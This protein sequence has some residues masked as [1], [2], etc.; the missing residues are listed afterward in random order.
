MT[1]Y[2]MLTASLDQ[3]YAGLS[4]QGLTELVED[5]YGPGVTPEDVEG[6]FDDIG[7]GLQH[8]AQG[9]GHFAQQAAPMVVKALRSHNSYLFILQKHH[10]SQIKWNNLL[11]RDQDGLQHFLRVKR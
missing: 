5:L 2:P 1:D 6:F 11:E 8:A 10:R 7:R 3:R 9:V 4:R